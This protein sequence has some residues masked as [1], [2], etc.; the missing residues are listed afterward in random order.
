MSKEDVESVQKSPVNDMKGSERSD[1]LFR[2]SQCFYTTT[3]SSK[4]VNLALVQQLPDQQD[5][6]NPKEFWNEKFDP[7]RPQPPTFPTVTIGPELS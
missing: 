3:E 6:R 5:K 7:Y 2:V 1:D 4:S